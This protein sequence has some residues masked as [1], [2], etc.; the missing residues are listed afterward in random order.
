VHKD[1]VDENHVN[2]SPG[3]ISETSHVT[4]S[5]KRSCLET[6]TRIITKVTRLLVPWTIRTISLLSPMVC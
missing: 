6:K 2:Y 1:K 5:S 4:T 3:D